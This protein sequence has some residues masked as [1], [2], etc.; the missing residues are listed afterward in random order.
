MI[1]KQKVIRVSSA[2][3]WMHVKTRRNNVPEKIQR[4][5]KTTAQA[6]QSFC[7]FSSFILCPFGHVCQGI[8]RSFSVFMT[9]TLPVLRVQRQ[10]ARKI[11]F[12][13]CRRSG[14][15]GKFFPM[16]LHT[17]SE[18]T[19]DQKLLV[20]LQQCY[21]T[22]NN[23]VESSIIQIGQGWPIAG[24]PRVGCI[25]EYICYLYCK[26]T[27]Q[28]AAEEDFTMVIVDD[29]HALAIFVWSVLDLA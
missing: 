21:D 14:W 27:Q 23:H 28:S 7:F 5:V 3:E 9:S 2:S 13:L 4:W 25:L 19:Y 12:R 26:E 1:C 10:H 18:Q 20:C 6:S 16:Q 15:T 17:S 24:I 22:Q 8:E 11:F 29:R